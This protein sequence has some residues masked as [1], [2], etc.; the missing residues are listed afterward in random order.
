MP[1]AV[2]LQTKFDGLRDQSFWKGRRAEL[3]AE[4][5]QA[6]AMAY[7]LKEV[8]QLKA[9]DEQSDAKNANDNWQ[10]GISRKV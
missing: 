4:K 8:E 5:V 1:E 3:L 9:F 2:M 6:V 7:C 10:S